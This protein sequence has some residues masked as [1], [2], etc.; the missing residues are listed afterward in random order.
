MKETTLTYID[1]YRGIEPPMDRVNIELNKYCEMI[2]AFYI[3]DQNIY[4]VLSYML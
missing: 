2:G 4:W 1:N 3:Y